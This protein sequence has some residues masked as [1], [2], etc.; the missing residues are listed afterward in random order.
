MHR[1]GSRDY[2]DARCGE[3]CGE[4]DY[5]R[6]NGST[7]HRARCHAVEGQRERMSYKG[8]SCC[9]FRDPKENMYLPFMA[10]KTRLSDGRAS[11]RS[12]QYC[13]ISIN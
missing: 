10:E 1:F 4:L 5:V 13:T 11:D 7:R 6:G 9:Q 8:L 2:Y 3:E 12:T